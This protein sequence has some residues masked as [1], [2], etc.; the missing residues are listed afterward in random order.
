M[1]DENHEIILVELGFEVIFE[2]SGKYPVHGYFLVVHGAHK[3][4][5]T[6][7]QVWV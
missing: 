5:D 3:S 2:K 4:L 7:R 1:K 6:G